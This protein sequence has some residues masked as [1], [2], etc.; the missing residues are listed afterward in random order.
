MKSDARGSPHRISAGQIRLTQRLAEGDLHIYGLKQKPPERPGDIKEQLQNNI[1]AALVRG[2]KGKKMRKKN[3]FLTFSYDDGVTQDKRLVKIFNKYHLKASFNI[4]SELLGR[5]GYLRRET[6]WIGHNKVEPREVSELYRGHEIAAH[7]LTHPHLPEL[8][9]EE[10]IRQVEQDRIN[11]ERLAEQPVYGLAYPG[12]VPTHDERVVKLIR[13]HTGIRYG[14][15]TISSYSFDV[16]DDLL[17]FR[18]TI[19]HRE[20]DRMMELGERF[21]KQ[22]VSEKPQIYYI[23]GHSY[24]FDYYDSWDLFEEFCKMMSG[25]EDIYY[26]TSQ[27]ILLHRGE[28]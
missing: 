21:I 5:P 26:G 16:Q 18:P 20:F 11:L 17:Q 10:V 2:G 19:S 3:K 9:D 24:E 4:N 13:E 28:L 25:R 8:S 22:A 14:R 15:T 6:M 23:W 7:T 1:A 12:G 27:E